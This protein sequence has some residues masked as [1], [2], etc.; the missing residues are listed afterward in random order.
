MAL[1]YE[2]HSRMYL[3][4]S[5]DRFYFPGSNTSNITVAEKL[6]LNYPNIS[7]WRF[8]VV[9]NFEQ[10]SSWSATD[11]ILNSPPAN[12]SCSISPLNGTT[13]TLFTITCLNWIDVDSIKD[14]SLFGRS[15]NLKDIFL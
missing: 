1:W 8:E 6:F 5:L 13:M 9:Y 11:F 15:L 2:N 14:Y 10:H 4:Q 12:G 3:K 7:Y